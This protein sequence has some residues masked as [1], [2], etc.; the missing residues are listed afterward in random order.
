MSAPSLATAMVASTKPAVVAA[1]QRDR[2]ALADAELGQR[3]GQR[4]AA[5]VH[6]AEGQLAE[7]VDQRRPGRGRVTA[8]VANPPAGPVPHCFR[9]RASPASLRGRVAAG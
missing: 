3:A 1:H 6:L 9:T 2:V 7:L 4:V 5:A 8:R